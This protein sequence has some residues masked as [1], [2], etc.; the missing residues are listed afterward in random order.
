[1]WCHL[2]NTPA[3]SPAA[4]A[5]AVRLRG[6]QPMALGACP[7]AAAHG[8]R[9]PGLIGWWVANPGAQGGRI[10][11]RVRATADTSQRPPARTKKSMMSP[12]DIG[13]NTE[14]SKM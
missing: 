7:E 10:G 12:A 9:W 14:P 2:T 4:I 5:A 1:M 6:G 3:P 11:Q 13:T 8:E